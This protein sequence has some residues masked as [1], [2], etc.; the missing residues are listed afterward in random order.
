MYSGGRGLT[1]PQLRTELKKRPTF[2]DTDTPSVFPDASY[3]IPNSI[4]ISIPINIPIS[5]PSSIPISTHKATS[6]L[7]PLGSIPAYFQVRPLV[8][9]KQET[10]NVRQKEHQT[11][12]TS[13]SNAEPSFSK[14][15]TNSRSNV[16]VHRGRLVQ[17]NKRTP[18][19]EPNAYI[20]VWNNGSTETYKKSGMRN[21]QPLKHTKHSG[22]LRETALHSSCVSPGGYQSD[23][24][25]MTQVRLLSVAEHCS[26]PELLKAKELSFPSLAWTLQEL[27]PTLRG[28]VV[29]KKPLQQ[30][31]PHFPHLSDK[32]GPSLLY[33]GSSSSPKRELF[34][35]ETGH[36]RPR[37]MLTGSSYSSIDYSH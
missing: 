26:S 36:P 25:R 9:S 12:V 37:E 24:P 4:P 13:V 11:P 8:H 27:S 35:I 3:S 16:G 17:D 32:G 29:W 14:T 34:A 22:P 31:E 20:L 23:F 33:L 21:L 28:C 2:P 30:L 5:I 18:S 19:E 6:L 15:K 10:Q 7:I 1:D